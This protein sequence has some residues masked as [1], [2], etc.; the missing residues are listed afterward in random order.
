MYEYGQVCVCHRLFLD[1]DVV[2]LAIRVICLSEPHVWATGVIG[3]KTGLDRR[4]TELVVQ[5]QA[6]TLSCTIV[7]RHDVVVVACHGGS[8]GKLQAKIIRDDRGQNKAFNGA[9]VRV[10]KFKR[11]KTAPKIVFEIRGCFE[12]RDVQGERPGHAS[13]GDKA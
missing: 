7:N 5:L 10:E 3:S 13:V 2:V 1:F 12:G 8:H 6:V 9:F 4:K 11:I